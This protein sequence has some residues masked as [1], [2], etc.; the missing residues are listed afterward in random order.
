M[1]TVNESTKIPKDTINKEIQ[2]YLDI[3]KNFLQRFGVILEKTLNSDKSSP[4]DKLTYEFYTSKRLSFVFD[5]SDIEYF[6]MKK[7]NEKVNCMR[8]Y[9]GAIWKDKGPKKM[10]DPTIILVP[11]IAGSIENVINEDGFAGVEWPKGYDPYTNEEFDVSED[12]SAD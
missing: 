9:L 1:L 2:L 12:N 7:G 8:A 5:K 4:L 6:F 10:G 11:A 3:R